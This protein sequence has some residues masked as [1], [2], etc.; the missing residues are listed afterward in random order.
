MEWGLKNGFLYL[1]WGISTEGKGSRVNTG[2]FQF[3]EGFGG[4]GVL[5]E[6]YLYTINNSK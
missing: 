3:K 1:D 2:L 6:S 4:H 5:R